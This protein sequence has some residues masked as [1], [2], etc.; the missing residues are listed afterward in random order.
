MIIGTL[1]LQI[2]A[3]KVITTMW[4]YFCALQLILL[5]VLQSKLSAP[6]SVEM[7]IGQIAGIINLSSLD[8]DKAAKLLHLESITQSAVFQSLDG[9][10][11][12][13]IGIL[14]AVFII[15][16][17]LLISKYSPRVY[18]FFERIKQTVFWNFLIRYFQASYIGFNFAALSNVIK[19]SSGL[20]DIGTSIG[21]LVSQYA[22]VTYAAY[23]LLKRDPEILGT[24]ETKLR[25]GHLYHNLDTRV[26][27]KIVFGLLFFV[28][29]SLIVLVLALCQ[30]SIIQ[31]QL[32]QIVLLLNTAYLLTVKPYMDPEN[33]VLDQVNCF[34][35]MVV[36]VLQSTYS[37]WNTV[38]DDRFL[39][40]MGF[41]GVVIL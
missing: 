38:T 11:L 22:L 32:S 28:Q 37:I 41:D 8:K 9:V 10:A 25:I 24:F 40:G 5:I 1:V 2:I 20:K 4:I 13:A 39:Y 31:W 30:N 23:I 15:G 16:F 14:L 21:I 12:S 19:A 34:F 33:A 18:E 7:V 17:A 3:K 27:Q 29:R 35:L 36:S 26:K 6:A